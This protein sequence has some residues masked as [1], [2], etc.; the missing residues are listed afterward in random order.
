M[1]NCMKDNL[2][3]GLALVALGAFLLFVRIKYPPKSSA[4]TDIYRLTFVAIMGLVA[5]LYFIAKYFTG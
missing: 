3:Y 2:I 1:P 4:L 5:G